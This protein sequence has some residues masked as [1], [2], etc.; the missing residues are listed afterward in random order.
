MLYLSL[1]AIHKEFPAR[2]KSADFENKGH[3]WTIAGGRREGGKQL[4][5]VCPEIFEAH[6]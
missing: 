3:G 1:E 2:S 5:D 4:A 6:T